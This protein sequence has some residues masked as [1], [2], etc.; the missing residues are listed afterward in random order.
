MNYEE[1]LDEAIEGE[2]EKDLRK[3]LLEELGTCRG[4]KGCVVLDINASGSRAFTFEIVALLWRK[5]LLHCLM[6]QEM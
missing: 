6:L 5:G 3:R 2:V 4:A 1:V